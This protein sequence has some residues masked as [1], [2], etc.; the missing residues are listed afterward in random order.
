MISTKNKLLA[1]A[2]II[3]V[4]VL[5]ITSVWDDSLIVD[6]IP[7]VGAGYSYVSK[8][9]YRLNPEHPPL[10]KDLAA[11]PLRFLN[12]DQ[13]VFDTKMWL[14]D[15]NGQWEFGRYLIYNSGNDAQEI[16]HAV[17]LPMLI[18]FILSAA[19]IFRWGYELYGSR[20]AF[21][22]LILFAFSPTVV[23][24]S[25]FV[26]TDMAALFG[27]LYATYFFVRYLRSDTR[28]NFWLASI[29]FGVALLAKFS[30]ILL[31]PFFILLAL[32][33]SIVNREKIVNS[34]FPLLNSIL[35]MLIGVLL[36][37]WP[38]YY[39]HVKNYPPERQKRDT[40]VILQT[41]FGD[42]TD[43]YNFII[44]PINYTSDKPAIR[45]L[46]QY[47]LGLARVF[48]QTSEP[49][50]VYF[51]GD[52]T[53]YGSRIYFPVVYFLKEPL[54]WWLLAMIAMLFIA[55]QVN[56]PSKK[57][58]RGWGKVVREHFVEFAL[59]LW[60]LI[61]WGSSIKST[62]NIGV[63]HLLPV[64]P[65]MILLV[66]GQLSKLGSRVHGLGSRKLLTI[67]Y[68]LFSTL[69]SWYVIENIKIFPHYLT[70]FNQVVGGPDNGYKYVV[71]SNLD[72]GQ[73]LVRFSKWVK[74]N[75]IQRIETDY[76]GW[77]DP[78]YYMGT[79]YERLWSGKYLNAQDFIARNQTDGWLAVSATFLMGSEGPA[80]NYNPNNYL[81]LQSYEPISKIGN[82]IFVY[83]I[84]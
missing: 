9:D 29:F 58:F 11:L 71:D 55:W 64:Y 41:V 6:E 49:H 16:T 33:Y 52:V 32:V 4:V 18:F 46:S 1:G 66:S 83:R 84:K 19:L 45:A 12:L 37:V 28:K 42:S 5:A 60:L 78:Y 8:G 48:H 17:K 36:V 24:H 3:T 70:Y 2:I 35:V 40:Q 81:W 69:L 51:L 67:Y 50:Y 75:N 20:G 65:F 23:A 59:V 62:L 44:K 82:S 63:R 27:I 10:A 13:S 57:S 30:T 72:W 76:F 61:Y 7:H 80:N 73:D 79:A 56:G 39:L 54:A 31:A 15:I 26:T 38:V 43:R 53:T 21:L 47:G 14:S 68:L 25:R 22:A 77:A 74:K 34:Y